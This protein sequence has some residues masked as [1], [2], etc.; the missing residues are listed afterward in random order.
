MLQLPSPA[1]DMAVRRGSSLLIVRVVLLVSGVGWVALG[2]LCPHA[3]QGEKRCVMDDVVT[4][5]E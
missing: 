4:G 2:L 3:H 1:G 5:P